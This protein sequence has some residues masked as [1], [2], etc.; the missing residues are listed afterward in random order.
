MLARFT[1]DEF[2]K[3]LWRLDRLRRR[4]F[5]VAMCMAGGATTLLVHDPGTGLSPF[6]RLALLATL[7][8]LPNA[9][10]AVYVIAPGIGRARK[11]AKRCV[12]TPRVRW[13]TTSLLQRSNQ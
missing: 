12:T 7:E 3:P 4:R 5:D 2:R 10:V 1:V 13:R 6:E 8:R 9:G 11:T